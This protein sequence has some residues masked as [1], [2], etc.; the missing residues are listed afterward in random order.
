[1]N[2]VCRSSSPSTP[3]WRRSG[4]RLLLAL[5]A[6]ASCSVAAGVEPERARLLSLA[7]SVLKVEAIKGQGGYSL[8]TG[9]A[10]APGKFVTNCHVTRDAEKILLVRGGARWA[11]TAELADP[12]LDLCVL[13]VPDLREVP[14]I[15][16]SSARNLKLGQAVAAMGFTGGTGLQLHAGLVS[17]L[18]DLNG[19]MVIQTTTAFTSGASGGALFDEDGHLVGILTF[20]LR[21]ADGYYFSAPIDWIAARIG[22]QTGYLKVAP[23]EGAKAFWAQPIESLPWFMQAAS[24]E[25]DGKWDE[26]LKL[27][28][29]WSGVEER[30]AEPW[31]LRGNS[32]A[33]LDRVEGAVKAYRKAVA[34]NPGFGQAWFNL[35][36]AYARLGA[37]DEV[38]RVLTVLR[39]I[40]SD[41]ADEL[42]VKSTAARR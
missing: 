25:A 11:A 24:L 1:M 26:L 33:K 30:N 35:G 21:G 9:V 42:S 29:K 13:D 14:P 28:E 38:Q 36:T 27:T 12:F 5:A 34:L 41:L 37:P 17:G 39:G 23:I 7:G 16:L 31:F 19:S 20:R 22:D 32:Y 15:P 3:G 2:A 10:I 8:G 18:H 6:W 4:C 40:D